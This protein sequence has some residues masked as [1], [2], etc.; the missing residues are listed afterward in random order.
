M[1]NWRGTESFTLE[2]D[3]YLSGAWHK[4]TRKEEDSQYNAENL[5]R[6]GKS[7]AE[8]KARCYEPKAMK[9]RDVA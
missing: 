8:V 1:I 2:T 7:E 4:R 9:A 3:V 5:T 6:P